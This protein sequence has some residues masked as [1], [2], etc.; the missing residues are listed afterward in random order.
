MAR[1]KQ[2]KKNW[3]RTLILIFAIPLIVWLAAFLAWLYWDSLSGRSVKETPR[4]QEPK[5]TPTIEK[6]EP[7]Q[8]EAKPS[9]KE[10][11]TEED[12][13]KLEDLLKRRN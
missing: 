4:V 9:P 7:R 8:P 3:L 12:R 10:K 11:I 1:K 2:P 5:A 13:R 6:K